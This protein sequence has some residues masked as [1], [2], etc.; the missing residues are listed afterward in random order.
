LFHNSRIHFRNIVLNNPALISAILFSSLPLSF[1]QHLFHHSRFHF[2]SIIFI[3]PASVSAT[4]FLSL[5][6]P[7][8]LLLLHHS[9][10]HFS[11]ILFINPAQWRIGGGQRGRDAPGGTFEGE[12]FSGKMVKFT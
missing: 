5:S 8:Q 4:L 3:D 9:R 10:F 1:Q 6:L 2:S 7:F 11:N 12:A